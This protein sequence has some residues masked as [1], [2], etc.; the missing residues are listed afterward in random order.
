MKGFDGN[1][2]KNLRAGLETRPHDDLGE[3]LQNKNC[4]Q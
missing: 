3:N 2:F 4:Q 1:A